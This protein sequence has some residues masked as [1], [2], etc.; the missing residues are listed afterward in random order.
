[1]GDKF[2]SEKDFLQNTGRDLK[3]GKIKII[4]MVN[5]DYFVEGLMGD[6]DW[7][8]KE[9]DMQYIMKHIDPDLIE[10]H[11]MSYKKAER[12]KRFYKYFTEALIRMKAHE[13]GQAGEKNITINPEILGIDDPTKPKE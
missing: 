9:E 5:G 11:D 7:K 2:K 10:F 1:M 13:M 12:K 6:H 8:V 4:K 3:T